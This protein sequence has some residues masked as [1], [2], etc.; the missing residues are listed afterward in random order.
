MRS[1][2][3]LDARISA[4]PDPAG[5]SYS[6]IVLCTTY[7][8]GERQYN[9]FFWKLLRRPFVALA[10]ASS[11]APFQL[12]PEQLQVLVKNDDSPE[13]QALLDPLFEGFSNWVV[14]NN[15]TRSV[16]TPEV[17]PEP[18]YQNQFRLV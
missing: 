4:V 2:G 16:L 14:D 9:E 7:P 3:V 1:F 6:A 10:A 12:S 5:K 18:G 8:G 11:A 13:G 15:L 17:Q